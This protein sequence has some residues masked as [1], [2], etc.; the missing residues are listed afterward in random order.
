MKLS[1]KVVPGSSRNEIV[2]WLDDRLK[3]RVTAPPE[4]G[5]ANAT[6][7]KILSLKLNI[8]KSSIIIISGGTTPR[9]IIEIGGLLEGEIKERLCN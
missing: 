4:S 3:I 1:L 7:I 5:Q 6:V 2:G 8:P 9:K